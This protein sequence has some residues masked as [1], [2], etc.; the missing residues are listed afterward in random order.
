MDK[1]KAGAQQVAAE[2][3]KA[4]KQG[5]DKL[6]E[7]QAKKKADG[8]L[9]DLGAWR[10]AVD[11][12]RDDGRAEAELA[13]LAAE[14]EAFEAENGAIALPAP[15]PPPPAPPAP[16]AGAAAPPPPPG[17]AVPPP[18]PP[19]GAASTGAPPAGETF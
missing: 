19:T 7:V 12:G 10:Y 9:R 2:A 6:D 16:P 13:R 15:P 18:P 5:Q 17:A 1:V 11:H 8:L 14:L 4:V 3:E